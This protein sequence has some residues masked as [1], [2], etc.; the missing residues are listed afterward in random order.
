MAPVKPNPP[1]K[2]GV[3][4]TEAD[5]QFLLTRNVDNIFLPTDTY[6]KQYGKEVTLTKRPSFNTTGKEI[7]LSVNTYEITD[8]PTKKIFQ[9]DVSILFSLL[10][11]C[12]QVYLP[13][14]GPNWSRCREAHRE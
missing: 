5:E 12:L 7:T 1:R 8:F 13:D 6:E 10:D 14:V 3:D 4:I 9:Y 2:F 11:P